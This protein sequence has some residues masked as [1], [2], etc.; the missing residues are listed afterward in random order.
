MTLPLGL[1]WGL[2]FAAGAAVMVIEIAG[3]R[4]LAPTYGVSSVPWAGVISAVLLG[5]AL[6]NAWGGRRAA[7]GRGGLATLL[8]GAGGLALVPLL[9][10]DLPDRLLDL[11]GLPAGVVATSLLLFLPASFLLGAVVPLLVQAGTASLEEVG[12]RTGLLNGANALGAIGGTL[13]TGF[14]LIPLLPI[15]WIVGLAAGALGL[16]AAAVALLG[17]T[18]D[19]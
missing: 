11:L 19:A 12:R 4:L 18:G 6:G 15:S 10:A 8:L 16:L 14:V 17:R 9:R 5:V 13:L 3:A 2:S 7:R 1:L